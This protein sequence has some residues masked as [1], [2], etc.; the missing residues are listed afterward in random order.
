MSNTELLVDFIANASFKDIEELSNLIKNKQYP[1]IAYRNKI[2]GD[3]EHKVATITLP[4]TL[5]EDAK[6]Y[7]DLEKYS[8]N[9]FIIFS[10]IRV[11]ENKK[12]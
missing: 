7:C 12:S 2:V 3:T 4:K 10:L 8:L 9:D 11:L 1:N 5:Y 6:R